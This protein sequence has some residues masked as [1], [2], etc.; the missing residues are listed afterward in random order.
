MSR[1]TLI[2][3]AA[4]AA[5]MLGS[6]AVALVAHKRRWGSTTLIVLLA[7]VGSLVLAVYDAATGADAPL[8]PS[9]LRIGGVAG[10][11]LLLLLASNLVRRFRRR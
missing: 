5:L 11:G 9:V 1:V 3:M 7:L 8:L 10:F 2:N 6:V 4:V